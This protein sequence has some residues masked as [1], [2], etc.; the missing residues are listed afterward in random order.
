MLCKEAMSRQIYSCKTTQTVADCAKLMRDHNIGFVP[1]TENNQV[2]GTI[3]DRDLALRVLATGRLSNT[4]LNE[5]MTNSVL[6]C[7]PEDELRLAEDQMSTNKKSRIIVV[8]KDKHP[9]GVV[10]LSD[11]AQYEDD[12]NTA[13]VFKSVTGRES[14][15]TPR[16]TAD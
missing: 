15:A 16:A 9:V 1:I 12:R 3:T 11:I 14:R 4:R 2:V 5:V 7:K 10:S 8:D 6:T 13:R